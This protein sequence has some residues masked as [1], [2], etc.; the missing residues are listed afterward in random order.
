MAK[1]RVGLT[2]D[3]LDS[4][5]PACVWRCGARPPRRR[6]SP[7]V[8]IYAGAGKRDHARPC[9]ALRRAIRQHGESAWQRSR[10]RRSAP[11]CRRAARGGVR[12]GRRA[13]D[14]ESRRAR[15]QHP[16]V[17]AAARGDHR[18]DVHARTRRQADAE[19][20]AYAHRPV[21]RPDGQHGQ[22]IDRPH[23]RRRRRRP[24]RQG[25]AADGARVR[26]CAARRRSQRRR[27]RARVSRRSQGRSRHARRAVRLRR[28][29]LLARR[30]DAAPDRAQRSS[31]G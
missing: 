8:G 16:V 4:S 18:A 2:R 31:R 11:A 29:L 14:D 26:R 19:R 13:G 10:P 15:H 1:F 7:R 30:I 28:R 24:D 23:A 21:E 9:G 25:A 20:S 5:R 12:F 3:I 22:R 6:R 27:D 17:D